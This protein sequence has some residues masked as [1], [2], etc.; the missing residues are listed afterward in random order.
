MDVDFVNNRAWNNRN[1]GISSLLACTRASAGYY[2]NADGTLQ[3]FSSNDTLRYGTNGLLVEEAR[4][5]LF[6]RSQEFDNATITKSNCT[7]TADQAAAPD[8]TTTAD[9]VNFTANN[10]FFADQSINVSAIPYTVS[11]YART[12]SGTFQFLLGLFDGTTDARSSTM[13]A[14]TAWQRFSFTTTAAASASADG[15]ITNGTLNTGN[16]LMWGMQV[17]AGSFATSYVPTSGSTATRAAD[18]VTFSDTAWLGGS[19]DSIYA[20][21]TA[22]NINNAKV[23]AFD[24]TNDKLLDEQTGMSARIAGATVANTAAAGTTVKA[25][26]RM[27]LN[28]FAISMNGGTVA[29]DT[30]ETAPGTLSASRLGVDLS[31]SNSLN[32]YIRRVAA[33]NGAL[34]SD[35]ALQLL[36]R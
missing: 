26:V 35:S 3:N 27:A 21:W 16:V 29:T 1:L 14:T 5:N 25:A 33:F 10:G 13:T 7:I 30:S 22:A 20:E 18:I 34:L 2:T 36:S 23:W 9:N 32:S 4:T 12:T 8:G 19:A 24:A 11:L 15:Y 31:G 6:R 28:N 17:E